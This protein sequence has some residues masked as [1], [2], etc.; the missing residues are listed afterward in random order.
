MQSDIS[1]RRSTTTEVGAAELLK[2]LDL[3][4]FLTMEM[5]GIAGFYKQPQPDRAIPWSLAFH[6]RTVGS[7]EGCMHV[8]TCSQGRGLA[9]A[10]AVGLVTSKIVPTKNSINQNSWQQ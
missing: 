2:G 3:F 4:P 7:Q 1:S 5:H 10:V 6:G 8:G 9:A